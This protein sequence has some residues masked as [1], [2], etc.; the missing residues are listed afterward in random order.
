MMVSIVGCILLIATN[1]QKLY[2][3]VEMSKVNQDQRES[4]EIWVEE[5]VVEEGLEYSIKKYQAEVDVYIHV[6]SFDV[7]DK[8]LQ[9]AIQTRQLPDVFYVRSKA[10]V[11]GLKKLNLIHTFA[12]G[13]YSVALGSKGKEQGRMVLSQTSQLENESTLKILLNIMRDV[14]KYIVEQEKNVIS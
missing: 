12:K 8:M 9:K 10:E 11:E 1:R 7:Y 4:I 2:S 6:F 13:T 3:K 5:G 14:S